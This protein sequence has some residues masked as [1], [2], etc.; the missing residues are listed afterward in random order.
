MNKLESESLKNTEAS[1]SSEKSTKLP[2]KS[3]D[4]KEYGAVVDV[5]Q[6]ADNFGDDGT[7]GFPT[8][9]GS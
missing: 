9:S 1:V 4:F 8:D 2:Y 3:P 7:G 5:V 6:S